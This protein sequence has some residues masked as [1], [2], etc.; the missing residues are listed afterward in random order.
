MAANQNVPQILK[1][2]AT[3]YPWVAWVGYLFP[4]I[5]TY[6]INKELGKFP[7]YR[8]RMESIRCAPFSIHITITG[9]TVDAKDELSHQMYRLASI[10][11]IKISVDRD[12]LL[13][14]VVK[15]SLKMK[16]PLLS[17]SKNLI[18]GM[19]S[20]S[21]SYSKMS[22]FKPDFDII[23]NEIDLQKGKIEFTDIGADPPLV[24]GLNNV[25]IIASDIRLL[26]TADYNKPAKVFVNADTCEGKINAKMEVK[27]QALSPD[28]YLNVGVRDINMTCLNN[29]FRNYG[30]FDIHKGNMAMYSEITAAHGRFKGYVESVISDLEIMGPEDN[31]DS[32]AKYL[33]KSLLS[34]VTELLEDHTNDELNAKIEFEKPFKNPEVN[35]FKAVLEVLANAFVHGLTPYTRN[36]IKIDL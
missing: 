27:P 36:K 19:K 16:E 11:D 23:I 30:K 9:L 33:W 13:Q 32:L 22:D 25:S 17:I 10:H 21:A 1:K 28:F 26:K 14:S 20:S 4:S 12:A 3:V 7:G 6:F 35:V 5:P 8:C 2:V 31:H 29:V 24:M 15:L 18:Q 34:E